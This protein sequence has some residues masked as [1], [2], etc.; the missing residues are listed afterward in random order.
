MNALYKPKKEDE[1]YG[2]YISSDSS[3]DNSLI[4][5]RKPQEPFSKGMKNLER[6]FRDIDFGS[7]IENDK[8]QEL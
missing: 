2:N 6:S 4:D 1:L 8:M 5:D 7:D 3:S